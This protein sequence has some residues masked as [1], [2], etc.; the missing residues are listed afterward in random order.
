[1]PATK[2]LTKAAPKNIKR[3]TLILVIL[4]VAT[5]VS[6]GLFL[7][8]D[9]NGH[10]DFALPRRATQVAAF[11]IVGTAIAA[12]TVVFH[13]L[14]ANRIL[15][16]SIMGFDALYILIATTVMFTLGSTTVAGIPKPLM[17]TIN[18]A[19]MLAG[20]TLL[21]RAILG[22]G[23]RGLYT[24]ILVGVI[25]GTLMRSLT[26]FMVRVMDP[27]EFDSLMRSLFASFNR[28]DGTLLWV[29][30]GVLGA[31]IGITYALHRRL[32]VMTLGRDRAISL[33][34]DYERTQTWLLMLIALLV[35]VSTALVGPITFLGLL[36]ANLAYQLTRTYRHA[37]NLTVAA[38]ISV[39]AL[40]GGQ[41][42]L[43]HVFKFNATLPSL[44]NLVGGVYIIVLIVKESRR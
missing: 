3:E 27:N 25:V 40:I 24:L 4:I 35:S 41:A 17:F 7:T 11:L 8:W 13:T 39:I 18:T 42:M 38:L 9:V 31:G 5:L 15:T 30:A 33:G 21:F 1:M 12:S 6:I 23:K 19:L 44:I 36:V 34:L 26:E 32:D 10:W 16:P 14:T 37:L 22:K 43:Q 28:I 20:A 2:A 29:C